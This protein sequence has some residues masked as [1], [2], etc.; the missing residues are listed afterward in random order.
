VIGGDVPLHYLATFLSSFSFCPS[1]F[2]SPL[3]FLPSPSPFPF[4]SLSPSF[5]PF[6]LLF[7]GELVG[8]QFG[9][10]DAPAFCIVQ[11]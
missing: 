1:S 6:P 2:L 10:I 4:F 9:D 5:F 3:F 8:I 7:S 11:V